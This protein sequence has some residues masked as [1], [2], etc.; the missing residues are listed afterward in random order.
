MLSLKDFIH[1]PY[2]KC[3]KCGENSFSV[4][5][6]CDHHYFRRCTECYYPDPSKGEKNH[7]YLLPKLNKKVIYIDQFAISNM[8]KFLNPS[9]KSHE[10]VKADIF[11]GKL[12]EQLN[13]L[14]KL[15]LIICPDSDMHETEPLLVPYYK[16]L[17]RIYEL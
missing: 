1:G 5:I 17:K 2:I 16:S 15:Q 4:S 3:P 8:M 12:F 6:I 14:C 11:W 13:T 9:V 10:K 7:K